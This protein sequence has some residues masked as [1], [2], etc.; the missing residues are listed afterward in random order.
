MDA[1]GTT[2]SSPSAI[3]GVL[4]PA[5]AAIVSPISN[6]HVHCPPLLHHL[7]QH[8]IFD[9]RAVISVAT[10]P[11]RSSGYGS[12]GMPFQIRHLRR[13]LNPDSTCTAV[14]NSAS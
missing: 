5:M 11:S 7:R 8:L 14:S 13:H 9:R 1:G 6:V 4:N 12:S 2:S 3:A 10:C